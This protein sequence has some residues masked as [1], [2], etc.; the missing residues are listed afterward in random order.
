M[1]LTKAREQLKMYCLTCFLRSFSPQ[2]QRYKSGTLSGA[3]AQAIH[4]TVETLY[5]DILNCR[6]LVQGQWPFERRRP[7]TGWDI[8]RLNLLLVELDHSLSI[9]LFLA[10]T[11]LTHTQFSE[12][13]PTVERAFFGTN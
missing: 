3:D 8:T 7:I 10:A 9:P 4:A 2:N 13:V 6:K 12:I 5:Q 1:N 11:N